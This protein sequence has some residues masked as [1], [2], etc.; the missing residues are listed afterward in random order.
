MF[1]ARSEAVFKSVYFRTG[2]SKPTPHDTH[3]LVKTFYVYFPRTFPFTTTSPFEEGN[4]GVC[5]FCS[6][7]ARTMNEG[8]SPDDWKESRTPEF[9]QGWIGD[10]FSLTTITDAWVRVRSGNCGK[11]LK[12]WIKTIYFIL[13]IVWIFIFDIICDSI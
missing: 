6:K 13:D 5:D 9:Y 3:Q 11:Y 7:V 4:T 1:G 2:K 8:S 10:S 12:S